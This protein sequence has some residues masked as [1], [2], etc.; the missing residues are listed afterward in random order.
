MFALT[1]TSLMSKWFLVDEDGV[2]VVPAK[3]NKPPM[4]NFVAFADSISNKHT[5][6]IF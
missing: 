5:G 2:D 1:L 3:P 6:W 4:C